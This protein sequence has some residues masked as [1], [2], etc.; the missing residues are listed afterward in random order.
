[1]TNP[2]C[3]YF[4]YVGILRRV[5]WELLTDVSVNNYPFLKVKQPMNLECVTL[6]DRAGMLPLNVGN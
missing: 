6:E 1:M 2:I 4:R 5:E 3:K